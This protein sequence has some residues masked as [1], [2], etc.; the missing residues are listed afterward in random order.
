MKTHPRDS[1]VNP[2]A[3]HASIPSKGP[4]TRQE[5]KTNFRD[6][7]NRTDTRLW[8]NRTNPKF[9]VIHQPDKFEKSGPPLTGNFHRIRLSNN[10]FGYYS[11]FSTNLVTFLNLIYVSYKICGCIIREIYKTFFSF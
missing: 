8:V 3:G 7:V 10:R 5:K 4:S 2:C 11:N 9:T 1:T 6:P